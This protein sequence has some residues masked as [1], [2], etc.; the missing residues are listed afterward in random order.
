MLRGD[1]ED[2]VYAVTSNAV[3]QEAGAAV[4]VNGWVSTEGLEGE[5]Q[6]LLCLDGQLYDTGYAL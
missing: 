4:S 3:A 6:I 2:R 1:G 5:W